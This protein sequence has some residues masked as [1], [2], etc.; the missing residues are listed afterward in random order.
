MSADAKS[1]T[2]CPSFI[3][4]HL[5]SLSVP[6]GHAPCLERVLYSQHVHDRRPRHPH[7]HKMGG[8][9]GYFRMVFGPSCRSI[10]LVSSLSPS[11]GLVCV[12]FS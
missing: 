9:V 11:L 3:P 7:T 5:F 1:A 4:E 8:G 6:L 2:S 10:F 12:P